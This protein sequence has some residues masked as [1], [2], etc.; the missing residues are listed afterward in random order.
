M[1][2]RVALVL[3]SQKQIPGTR[4]LMVAL[5]PSV[6]AAFSFRQIGSGTTSFGWTGFD[7]DGKWRFYSKKPRLGGSIFAC[8]KRPTAQE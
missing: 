7:F 8:E 1:R 5:Y 4:R 6:P 3:W 2:S